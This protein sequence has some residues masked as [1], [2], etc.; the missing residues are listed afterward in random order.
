MWVFLPENYASHI[1][2]RHSLIEMSDSPVFHNRIC[3]ITEARKPLTQSEALFLKLLSQL[4]KAPV[5]T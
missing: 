1:N 3:A 4:S 2:F 5:S